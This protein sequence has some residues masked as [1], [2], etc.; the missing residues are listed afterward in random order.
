MRSIGVLYLCWAIF[1]VEG[2]TMQA[3]E[4]TGG[5]EFRE[6]MIR[7]APAPEGEGRY[8]GFSLTAGGVQVPVY[9]CR[10]SAMPINQVWP[11][12]QRPEE[13]TEM[14]GFASWDMTGPV[15][16]EIHAEQPVRSVVVR[17]HSLGIQPEIHDRTIAFSLQHPRP[18]TVAVNGPRHVLHLFPNPP[19][20]DVPADDTPG[21][22]YFGPGVHRPGKI[23]LKSGESVYIAAGAVVYGSIHATR[24]ADLKVWG[25][26]ILDVSWAKRGQ[27]GGAV[28]FTDCRNI[29]IEGIVMR[30]PDVWC[31]SL[32]GCRDAI[33]D[34]VKL[35]GLWRYNA[36]GIDICNS[37][38]VTVRNSFVRSYD[39]SIVLKGLKWK[40]GYDDRPIRNIRVSGCT[41]WCD[42]GRALEIG[43]ETCA[44]EFD[45]IRF[46]DCDI[47]HT[48]HIAMDIQHGD[49]ALIHHVRFDDIRVEMDGEE[50][51]PQL[52][53]KQ[54]ETYT[55]S[56]K[57]KKYLPQLLVIVIRGNFY[58]KDS[59]R[60]NVRDILFRN[61]AI[62]APR[63]PSSSF[64]GLDAEHTVDGVRL[65]EF[66][67]NG[68]P[69][70]SLE[71]LHLSLGKHVTNVTLEHP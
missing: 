15:R 17:P 52:Q 49:R 45:D 62:V 46:V 55:E 65:E 42:W 50:L 5:G 51:P 18:V 43:A 39:D 48:A 59:E 31:C 26:G 60:G 9:A 14:A 27:G 47:V 22:H 28:R 29:R 71:A 11:G 34:N 6:T 35:V 25:R 40:G 23:V 7:A 69:V 19:E 30:D 21:L 12:Y 37:Q 3:L 41:L 67:F 63:M 32:F 66:S 70:T 16:V 58:S 10:V 1:A 61:I 38:D 68:K 20:T 56:Q 57:R 24:A 33:I 8:P 4:K 44:P 54:G 53:R 36:D 13:Q 2:K 64:Q